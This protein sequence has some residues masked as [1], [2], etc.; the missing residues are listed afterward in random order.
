M[1]LARQ[2]RLHALD[3][4]RAIMM[5][6]GIVLHVSFMH[7][8]GPT[9]L[10]WRDER[11]TAVADMLVTF[12]HA[13]R[14]P[15]FFILAG[16]FVALLAQRLGAM[17]M[18]RHRMCRLALPFAVFWPLL[19]FA[20]SL[21]GLAFLN[22]IA[23]GRWGL[24][25]SVVPAHLSGAPNTMH[26]WFLWMLIWYSVATALVLRL[27][28]R[29][30]G[31]WLQCAGNCLGLLGARWWGF[32]LLAL[33]LAWIGSAYPGGFLPVG[34]SFL[35]PPPEWL[36]HGLFFAFGLALF[37]HQQVLFAA[38]RRHWGVFAFAG[39]AFF[40]LALDLLKRYAPPF[41]IAYAY[42]A[43]AWLWSF[44][45]IGLALRVLDARRAWMAW[46]ADSAYW[47]YLVHMPLT[48][49][50]GALLFGL[51]LPAEVKILANIGVTTAVCLLTYAWWVRRGWIGVLLNGRRHPAGLQATPALG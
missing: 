50:F 12:I 34:G 11:R 7:V 5:W 30:L 35:P 13:F 24:D 31:A 22:R 43:A 29:R 6:L 44:A 10:P 17:G 37:A 25:E 20:S 1:D 2:P 41:F 4:L 23:H 47:V 28:G 3:N 9:S 48:M 46:L 40:L 42:N 8:V 36:H 49:V 27:G 19:F 51:P 14:M 21:A 33:P 32:V 26:L 18:L 45:W 39:L 15:V 16:F 38:Y